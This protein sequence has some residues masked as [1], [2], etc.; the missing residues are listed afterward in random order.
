MGLVGPNGAGKSTLMLILA[1]ALRPDRGS[2]RLNGRLVHAG[3]FVPE[4]GW[5][6]QNADDQLFCPTV[7]EDIAFGLRN[8]GLSGEALE[9]AVA[10][11]LD[12]VG[13]AA[14]ANRPV[15]QLSGGEKRLACLA[16]ALAVNPQILL[17]T[18]EV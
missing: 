1:G 17:L 10:C 14:L 11:M 7:A 9:A 16:G 13:I 6:F 15:H 4:I 12:R 8:L 3:G 18:G 5:V 2:V